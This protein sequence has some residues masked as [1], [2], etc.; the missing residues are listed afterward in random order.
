MKKHSVRAISSFLP[1][2]FC[3]SAATLEVRYPIHMEKSGR[4]SWRKGYI[5][6]LKGG[7]NEIGDDVCQHLRDLVLY[8][9]KELKKKIG[10][11][12]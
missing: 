10:T 1:F 6:C 9:Q 11:L 12:K 7:S 8:C 5:S 4:D 3:M 2:L